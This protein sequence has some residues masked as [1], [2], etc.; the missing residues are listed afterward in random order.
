[1]GEQY[2]LANTPLKAAHPP[3]AIASMSQAG[4]VLGRD[5]TTMWVWDVVV[6][7]LGVV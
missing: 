5:M 1:V 6:A 3:L 4:L 2:S 7:R